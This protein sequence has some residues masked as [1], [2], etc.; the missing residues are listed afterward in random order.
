MEVSVRQ[1]PAIR[2]ACI[3][4]TGSYS[5]VRE[6]W[7]RIVGWAARSGLLGRGP[8]VGVVHDIPRG[9]KCQY[10]AGVGVGKDVTAEDPVEIR[11]TPAGLY[12]VALHRGAYADLRKVYESILDGWLKEGVYALRA[13]QPFLE[14]FLNSPR[15]VPETQLLTEV[16]IPVERTAPEEPLPREVEPGLEDI[17]PLDDELEAEEAEEDLEEEEAEA[18]AEAK[19]EGAEAAGGEAEAEDE[20]EKR[21]VKRGRKPG[22]AKAAAPKKK[23]PP[24]KEKAEKPGKA[25]KKKVAAAAPKKK[26][27]PKKPAKKK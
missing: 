12:A 11:A 2:V 3:R 1:I 21:P 5:D 17:E 27:A 13:G 23:A 15:Q 4:H 10:D 18:E 19:G 16:C 7:E 22:P 6:A 25:P 9:Q 26:A 14:F 24:K 20:E 8:M